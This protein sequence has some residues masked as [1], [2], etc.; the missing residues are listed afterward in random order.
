M[1]F[2]VHL[3]LTRDLEADW[4]GAV[5]GDVV[6]GADLS[7]YPPR[8]AEGIRLHRRIDRLTDSHPAST[9]LRAGFAAGERRYAGILLDLAADPA[10]Y[11]LWAGLET[12]PFEAFCQRA[13]QAVAGAGPWFERAG[14]RAPAA[15]AF[16][17]L[18]RGAETVE[19]AQRALRRTATRLRE[20]APLLALE[21]HLPALIEA[22]IPLLPALLADL[23]SALRPS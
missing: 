12:E 13:A 5:L 18:L 4:A 7:A 16:E 11:R 8:L 19:G 22:W 20:P 17:S 1:N 14:A 9:A 10:L 23:R 3:W 21:G 2:L 15:A 6:R